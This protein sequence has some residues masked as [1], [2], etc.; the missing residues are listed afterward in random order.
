MNAQ[1]KAVPVN[2]RLRM[3]HIRCFLAVAK[4]GT[5]TDAATAMH[6]S[7]PAIS[8]SLAEIEEII[9]QPLFTRTG[10]GLVMTDA[11]QKLN[12][13]LDTAMAQ[14]E[15]GTRAASGTAPRPRVALGMLPNVARTLAV[16]AGA[17]FKAAHPEIDLSLYW[18]GVS[19]LITRL[20]RNEIDFILG[21]LLSLEHM[22]GVSFEHLYTE[23]LVFVVSRDHPFATT[24]DV[25]DLP[26]LMHEMMI[27]PIADTIIRRE[28]DKFLTA[29]GIADFPNKIETVSF[30]FTRSY[31]MQHRGAACVPVGAV[32]REL[33]DGS[34]VRL[35]IQGEEL[36]SSVGITYAAGRALSDD[37]Q[38]LA[39]HV[40]AA[41]KPK[42]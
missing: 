32:R 6:S 1:P 10:R 19:E 13:H 36:V 18:A 15:T 16:D 2:N 12:R 35:G 42:P 28:L 41:V 31:L 39:Q 22:S 21:R 9:G 34:L 7:Q 30:E 24:P 38:R 11:G 20:H 29:R 27:V 14:I 25:I 3:R 37:A 8:R 33:A 40:R 5:V 23:A 17:S 4:A 26:D